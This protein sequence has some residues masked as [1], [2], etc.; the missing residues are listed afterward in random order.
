MDIICYSHLRWNFVYQRPQ[1]LLSRMARHFRIFYIEEPIFDADRPFLDNQQNEDKV[2][3]VVP[4]LKAG[5]PEHEIE[6][7]QNILLKDFLDYFECRE[8]IAWYYTPM[9]IGL[10]PT[11]SPSLVVYDCMDELAAFKNAPASLKEKEADL[12][13]NAD[14]VFTGGYSLY[15][16]KKDKHP[17]VYLFP[18]SIDRKHFEK[19]RNLQ[20]DAVDQQHIPFPRIGFFGVVDERMDIALLEAIADKKPGWHFVIIGPVVKI[21]PETLPRRNNIHYLGPKSYKELPFYIAKWNV[22]MMPFAMNESTRF[23]SPTKTPEYLAAGKPVVSTAIFDVVKFYG[24]TG[25]AHI[26]ED[27]NGFVAAIQDALDIPDS[28][29]WLKTVD[30]SLSANSWDKT[31]EKMMFYIKN[32]LEAKNAEGVKQKEDEYV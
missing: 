17:N 18:S 11:F 12:L 5:L 15:N 2:W 16:A 3:V 9:A 1:H 8:F 13:H 27:A 24:D 23:I 22:A 30:L 25:L 32:A 21:D 28:A 26:A 14:I 19:A 29:K 4:H 7:Q 20:T 31:V 6:E 10:N